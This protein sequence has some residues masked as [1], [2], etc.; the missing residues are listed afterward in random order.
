M[1]PDY[2]DYA[3]LGYETGRTSLSSTVNEY[4]FEN[5]I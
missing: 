2:N 5:G 1:D 4:V 3:M